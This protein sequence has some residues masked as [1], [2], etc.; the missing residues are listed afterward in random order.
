MSRR[1]FVV[2]ALLIVTFG[3]VLRTLWLRADPPTSSVGVVWHDEGAWVHNARN[4]ALWGEW[5]LDRDNWNPVFIAPV[6]TALEYGAFE[7]FGVGTWQ[8]RTVPVVFGLLALAA[9]MAGLSVLAGRRAAVIGGLLLAGNYT[10]VMWNRAAL[11]ESTMTAFIVIGWAAYAMGARRPAWGFVA[12]AATVLAWFTKA[13]A[14]FFLA[15]IVADAVLVLGLAGL[16]RLRSRLGVEAPDPAEVRTAWRVLAGLVVAAAAIIVAFVAPHWTEYQFYNWQMTVLRKPSYALRDFMDRASWLPVVQDF[17]MRMWLVVVL[18]AVA[19]AGVAAR[20]REAKPAERLLVWWILVGMLELT[21]HDSGN[22][23]RYV[24]FIPALIALAALVI[25]SGATGIPARTAALPARSRWIA[26][27]LLLLLGYLV[28]GSGLRVF[29]LENLRPDVGLFRPV[30]RLSAGLAVLWTV[31]L[32]ARWRPIVTWLAARRIPNAAAAAVVAVSLAWNLGQYARWATTH[33]DLNYRAS[34]AIG[35]QLAA[36]T[37]VHGKLAS[38]LSLENRIRPIFVG[39]G[40]G[41]YDDRFARDDAR[42]I[43]TYVLPREG[44]ESQDGLIEEIL[45][46]YPRRR[47]VAT[48]DV[49][50]TPGLDRAALIDKNPGPESAAAGSSRA[51]D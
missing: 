20:W 29:F 45:V 32:M 16:P 1:Q 19:I 13:S 11:M 9:L 33:S 49:D 35:Q 23:R 48:F 2:I 21:I 40:F 10:W 14:A 15:A 3:G 51:P 4:R 36:G 43:L 12:G 34:V 30:V 18:A 47:I 31:L 44:Y 24:M 22:E 46:R 39:R 42:Y 5:I 8:A 27:P 37:L 25:G 28:L 17:F 7:A 38:G 26:V 41:N 6:F 50:E